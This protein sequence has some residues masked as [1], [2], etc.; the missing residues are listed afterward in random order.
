MAPAAQPISNSNQLEKDLFGDFIS[1]GSEKNDSGWEAVF[2]D[3]LPSPALNQPAAP[4]ASPNLLGSNDDEFSLKSVFNQHNK[5]PSFDKDSI[6]RLYNSNQPTTTNGIPPL[7]QR[8]MKLL[9]K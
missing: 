7:G 3:P 5:P 1:T 9:L 6:L 2:P 8:N 4:A